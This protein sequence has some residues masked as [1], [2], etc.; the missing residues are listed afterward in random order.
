M[1]AA[2]LL[3]IDGP[4][5]SG[6]HEYTLFN[7]LCPHTCRGVTLYYYS[8]IKLYMKYQFHTKRIDVF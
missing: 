1:A 6:A 8:N 7:I 5:H 4:R 3:N 2:I